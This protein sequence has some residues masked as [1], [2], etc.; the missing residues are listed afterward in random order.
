MNLIY[1]TLKFKLNHTTPK[2]EKEED[3]C[4]CERKDSIPFLDTSLSKEN[5]R[6]HTAL[7]KKDTDR[8]QYLLRESCHPAGVTPSIPFSLSLRMVRICCTLPPPRIGT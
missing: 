1:P 8:N 6:I 3:R 4:D 2:K 7:H 5:G